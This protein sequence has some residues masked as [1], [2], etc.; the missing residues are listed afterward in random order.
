MR[1]E[2]GTASIPEFAPACVNPLLKGC[3]AEVEA[4]LHCI[5]LKCSRSWDCSCHYAMM[6]T[7]GTSTDWATS[8]CK[9][10]G[11]SQLSLCLQIR[12]VKGNRRTIQDEAAMAVD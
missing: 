4:G 7:L 2:A 9:C 8:T 11:T 1:R 3:I 12:L 5:T 10:E 6:L